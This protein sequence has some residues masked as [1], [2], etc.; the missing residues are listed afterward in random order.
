MDL[1][2]EIFI[3]KCSKVLLCHKNMNIKINVFKE[4][5]NKIK[6]LNT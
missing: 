3:F 4:Q 2:I 1:N 6:I 5:V